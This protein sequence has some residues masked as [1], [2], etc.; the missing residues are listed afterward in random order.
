V[1][2]HTNIGNARVLVVA[3]SDPFA[4]LRIVG[5][6]QRLN[7]G[8]HIIVRTRYIQNMGKLYNLSA[9]K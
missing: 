3:I 6:A 4:T 9:M 8:V 2:R 1:L 7:E 5:L